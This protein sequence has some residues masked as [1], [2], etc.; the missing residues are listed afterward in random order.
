MMEN[1]APVPQYL[2]EGRK[3]Q[4]NPRCRIADVCWGYRG[5]RRQQRPVSLDY[6]RGLCVSLALLCAGDVKVNPGPA[7]SKYPCVVC[8]K[9]VRNNHFGIECSRCEIWT[10]GVCGWVFPSKYPRLSLLEFVNEPWY[11]PVCQAGLPF[12][13]ANR[14][15]SVRVFPSFVDKPSV[16]Q[17][18]GVQLKMS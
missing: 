12:C 4:P 8:G 5:V 15:S 3:D 9:A 2:R 10:H 16:V 18:S 7:G 11:C 6:W 13:D 17:M 1:H 14:N